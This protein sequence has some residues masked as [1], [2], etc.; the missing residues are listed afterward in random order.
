[1]EFNGGAGGNPLEM[2]F[3][4]LYKQP[5]SN[6]SSSDLLSQFLLNVV[7]M[8]CEYAAFWTGLTLES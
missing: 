6:W 5:I 1:M 4:E 7:E 3:R 8:E 2:M